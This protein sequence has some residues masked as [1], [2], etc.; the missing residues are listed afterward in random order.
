MGKECKQ[1]IDKEKSHIVNIDMKNC[2]TFS[3][4]TETQIETTKN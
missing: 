3:E 1:V 4:I 2:S